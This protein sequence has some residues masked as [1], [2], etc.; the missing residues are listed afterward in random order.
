MNVQ[1]SARQGKRRGQKGDFAAVLCP[2]CCQPTMGLSTDTVTCM[3][4]PTPGGTVHCNHRGGSRTANTSEANRKRKLRLKAT[5]LSR[6]SRREQRFENARHTGNSILFHGDT[7]WRRTTSAR[8]L[9]IA[10]VGVR[11]VHGARVQRRRRRR[12][13]RHRH[14]ARVRAQVQT[15]HHQD[16]RTNN[17]RKPETH[18]RLTQAETLEDNKKKAKV[19]PC[20][21]R[22]GRRACH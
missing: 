1:S 6:E 4:L 3:S 2:T 22:P 16:L 9:E 12:A 17:A 18:G 13:E 14:V 8:Y 15:A 7:G 20:R 11:G 21:D 19:A 5:R 10:R